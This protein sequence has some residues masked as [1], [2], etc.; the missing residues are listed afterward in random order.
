MI[1]PLA[2]VAALV[3]ALA[4][5][6]APAGTPGRMGDGRYLMGTVLD[7]E[8]YGGDQSVLERL[9]AEVARLE[10]L[11][12]RYD[13]ATEISRL[14]ASAGRGPRAVDPDLA[15]L[16]AASVE[17]AELTRGSF[18]VTVGPLLALWREAA[19]RDSPPAAEEIARARARV[20][21]HH[22]RV[23]LRGGTAELPLAGSAID[24][25]GVA[26]GFAID[27]G[28]ALLRAAGV[29]AA[30]LSFGGSS[31]HAYGAPPGERAWRVLL[32]DAAGGFA[33]TLAL[34]DRALSVS[35]S[36]GGGFE[37]AGRR[38]G[39]VI[40]PRTGEPLVRR[41]L[42][43]VVDPSGARAEALSTALLVLGWREGLALV[44]R[45]PESEALIVDGGGRR[46]QTR[47]WSTETGFE[48][49]RGSEP[50]PPA[51]ATR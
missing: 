36:L 50:Y 46:W 10:R 35:A 38:Y 34:R 23:D 42:A 16:L 47:G 24:L 21:A 2:L 18:D 13:P 37:I 39:H 49:Y 33:G 19:A 40:D 51:H 5:C 9:F 29:E 11:T 43:A 44:E 3:A 6:A 26:K 31:L 17:Y 8:L 15:R 25:G 27:R 32:R 14:N 22:L 41:R 12:S 48:P 28:V 45:L 4:A 20:G 30:L 7:V 1:A